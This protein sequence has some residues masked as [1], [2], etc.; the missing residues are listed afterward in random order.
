MPQLLRRRGWSAGQSES[1][2]CQLQAQTDIIGSAVRAPGLLAAIQPATK[3]SCLATTGSRY[4][5]RPARVRLLRT[6]GESSASCSLSRHVRLRPFDFFVSAFFAFSFQPAADTTPLCGA[7][8]SAFCRMKFI[9]MQARLKPAGT[10]SS[11][12]GAS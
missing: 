5:S 6:K 3:G 11:A 7:I 10:H 8:I 9:R 2:A 12:D 1:R 4:A